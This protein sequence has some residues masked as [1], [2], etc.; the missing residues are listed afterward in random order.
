MNEDEKKSD[1]SSRYGK[2]VAQPLLAVQIQHWLP[3][4]IPRVAET[5]V[6]RLD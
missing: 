4:R 5:Q 2:K 1:Q 3:G 6:S